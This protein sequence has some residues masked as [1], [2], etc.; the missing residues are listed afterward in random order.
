VAFFRLRFPQFL[1]LLRLLNGFAVR[2]PGFNQMTFLP[3]WRGHMLSVL[4][5]VCRVYCMVSSL[6][7]ISP[8]GDMSYL[9]MDKT[10]VCLYK[11][12]SVLVLSG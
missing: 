1:L 12:F 8:F 4:Y 10:C 9:I 5:I 11:G 2:S 7:I 3:L 6:T